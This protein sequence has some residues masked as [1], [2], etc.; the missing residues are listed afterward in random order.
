MKTDVGKK[1]RQA[2]IDAGWTLKRESNHLIWHC[3]CP[4]KHIVTSSA[5]PTDY[6]A[7]RNHRSVVRRTG[8]PNIIV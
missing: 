1:I 4:E 7:F 2:T 5:S 3:P 8:C 6:R